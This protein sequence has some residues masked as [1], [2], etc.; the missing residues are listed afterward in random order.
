MHS[1]KLICSSSTYSEGFRVNAVFN[2]R[3]AKR[4]LRPIELG[5]LEIKLYQQLGPLLSSWPCM[6]VDAW[7][8]SAKR[9]TIWPLINKKT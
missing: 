3:D 6:E 2:Q 5:V 4:Q 9:K 1:S 8:Y 7:V